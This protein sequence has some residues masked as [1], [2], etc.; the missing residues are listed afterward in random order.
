MFVKLSGKETETSPEQP[1]NA[2]L[3]IFVKLSGNETE[4]SLEQPENA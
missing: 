2:E 1:E 3:P 4:T